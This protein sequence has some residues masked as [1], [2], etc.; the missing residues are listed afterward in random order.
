MH[1]LLSMLRYSFTELLW[2]HF[3]LFT[4]KMFWERISSSKKQD[5]KWWMFMVGHLSYSLTLQLDKW[6]MKMK[7]KAI[8]TARMDTCV[9]PHSTRVR[10][11]VWESGWCNLTSGRWA[12]SGRAL[13][14]THWNS[15]QSINQLPMQIWFEPSKDRS[16]DYTSTHAAL[17]VLEQDSLIVRELNSAQAHVQYTSDS[18]SECFQ[19]T[20]DFMWQMFLPVLPLLVSKC[21]KGFC[22][23]SLHD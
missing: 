23:Y 6:G 7:K 12:I 10:E 1:Q 3:V 4:V 2:V 5:A 14:T 22:I 16:V 17:K 21:F 13:V 18:F 19:D 20:G 9:F 8:E 15:P 11:C